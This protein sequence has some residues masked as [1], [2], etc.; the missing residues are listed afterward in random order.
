M[1][2]I[3]EQMSLLYVFN[4]VQGILS[5]ADLTV[6]DMWEALS[7]VELFCQQHTDSYFVKSRCNIDLSTL[8]MVAISGLS[9][10]L[11]DTV[12]DRVNECQSILESYLD[13]EGV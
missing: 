9:S 2:S 6:A 7:I 5:K 3:Q 8:H 11:S 12:S 10:C 13:V 4:K 1:A